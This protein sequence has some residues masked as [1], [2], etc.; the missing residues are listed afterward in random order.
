MQWSRGAC[1]D[2]ASDKI[3][4]RARDLQRMQ[5]GGGREN[6]NHGEP[7]LSDNG[8]GG[9]AEEVMQATGTGQ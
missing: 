9:E 5:A 4:Q 1:G 6:G 7:G 8:S 3:P 2:G